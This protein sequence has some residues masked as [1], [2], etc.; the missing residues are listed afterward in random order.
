MNKG[1]EQ[2]R[3]STDGTGAPRRRMSRAERR[4]LEMQ[5]RRRKRRILIA[6]MIGALICIGLIIAGIAALASHFSGGGAERENEARQQAQ[7][8][9]IAG[10]TEEE[11]D[12]FSMLSD[13]ILQRKQKN[14]IDQKRF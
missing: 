14:V 10:E 8:L 4:R 6:A 5:R 1:E 9:T 3:R 11:Q 7:D 2:R 13:F 12:F